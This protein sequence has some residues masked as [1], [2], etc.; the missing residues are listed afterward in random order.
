MKILIIGDVN[1]NYIIEKAEWLKR[2]TEVSKIDLFTF[3]DIT[4]DNSTKLGYR[5]ICA[6]K[7]INQ[8]ALQLF[9]ENSKNTIRFYSQIAAL[10]ELDDDYDI[11]QVHYVECAIANVLPIL[12]LKCKKIIVNIWGSD[13]LRSTEIQ[14]QYRTKIYD[15]ADL[16]TMRKNDL[17]ISKF[18]MKYP[19]YENKTIKFV[20]MGADI[21]NQLRELM[22]SI[23]K[24]D[25]KK[26]LNLDTNKI[27]ITIG[28][29]ADYNHKHIEI[30]DLL[31]K[32]RTIIENLNNI[33][34]LLPL[35]Y[36]ATEAEK[37][38][39]IE[40]YSS[41]PIQFIYFRSFL[42]FS[43]VC[44]IRYASDI[45][46]NLLTTDAFSNSMREYLYTKNVVITGSWLPYDDLIDK[47]YYFRRI[48]SLQNISEELAFVLKNFKIEKEKCVINDDTLL[49]FSDWSIF[50]KEWIDIY[51]KIL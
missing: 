2:D 11:A 16:I 28:Y 51:K 46:I 35:T 14:D 45:F 10:F 4:S 31:L 34:F 43:Q 8:N 50:I 39:I 23:S 9:D 29:Q 5:T 22:N 21:F 38:K 17:I 30:L 32:E 12:K 20:K 13:L 48:K 49:A 36:G 33:I 7:Y 6:N 41:K 25:C 47:G 19:N 42:S 44:M 27:I 40:Y 3:Y 1:N 24:I 15:Q 18:R 37:D 26:I